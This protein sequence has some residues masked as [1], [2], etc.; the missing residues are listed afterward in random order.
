MYHCLGNLEDDYEGE[1][2]GAVELE[3]EL[4]EYESVKKASQMTG[5]FYVAERLFC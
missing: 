3:Y 4:E 1:V 5:F 2:E